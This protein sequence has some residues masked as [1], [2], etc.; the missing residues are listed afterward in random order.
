MPYAE[1]KRRPTCVLS[2]DFSNAFDKI[3]HEYIFQALRQY[4]LPESFVI[5]IEKMYDTATSAVQINRRQYGPI[6]IRCAIRQGCPLSMALYALCIHPLLKRLEHKLTGIQIGE[7]T[8]AIKVAAYP[9]DVT[10]FI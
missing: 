6:P 5:S 7:R 8:H 1:L 3:S 9:D 10:I 4:S 2:L